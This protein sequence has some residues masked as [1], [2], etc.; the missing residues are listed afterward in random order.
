M[1]FI[2]PD[3]SQSE[4]TQPE[5]TPIP[6]PPPTS[7]F[8]GR[9]GLRAGWSAL[10]FVPLFITFSIL[11]IV[12]ALAAAGKLPGV[13]ADMHSHAPKSNQPQSIPDIVAPRRLHPPDPPIRRPRPRRLHPLPHRASPLLRL[14]HWPQ[15]PVRLPP[16]CLLG[17]R[18]PQSPR[19]HPPHH[20]SSR[21]RRASPPRRR[22]LLLRRQMAARLHRRRSARGVPQPRLSPIHH[23]PR[24]LRSSRK[25]LPP[26]RPHRR[27]RNRRPL[28]VALLQRRPPR[29]CA[30]K[31]PWASS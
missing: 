15:P 27:F 14:R 11:F 1:T 22:H 23:H 6:P 18:N 8:L 21:L 17:T 10:I 12:T 24:C 5:L 9:F 30:R 26:P 20:A 7:I 4:P 28:H 29:Q 31:I 16:R 3:P 13:I 19:S 2:Q 25:N